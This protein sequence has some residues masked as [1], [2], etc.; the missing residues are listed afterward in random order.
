MGVLV[1]C[2]S[3]AYYFGL[4]YFLMALF[5]CLALVLVSDLCRRMLMVGLRVGLCWLLVLLVC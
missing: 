1:Y 5:C 2:C 4:G 3:V